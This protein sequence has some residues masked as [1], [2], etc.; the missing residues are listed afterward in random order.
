MGVD[1]GDIALDKGGASELAAPRTMVSSR[2][3][4]CF[5]SVTRAALA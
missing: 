1:F 3:P 2:R 5:R 4:R